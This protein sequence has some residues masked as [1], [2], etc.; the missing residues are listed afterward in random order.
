MKQMII[1]HV[2]ILL[3]VAQC[4]IQSFLRYYA[5]GMLK[6]AVI[7]IW[8]SLQQCLLNASTYFAVTLHVCILLFLI[9]SIDRKQMKVLQSLAMDLALIKQYYRY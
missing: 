8:P 4:S 2:R 1:L 9:A 5:R 6:Q 3:I 7:Q